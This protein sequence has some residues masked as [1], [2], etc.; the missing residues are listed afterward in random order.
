MS[1][2]HTQFEMQLQEKL[3]EFN[4]QHA[5]KVLRKEMV[6]LDKKLFETVERKHY[7]QKKIDRLSN[8]RLFVCDY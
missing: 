8:K 3:C 2:E 5:L 7:V 1:N 6:E 4:K